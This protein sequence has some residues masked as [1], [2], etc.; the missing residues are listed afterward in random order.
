VEPSHEPPGWWIAGPSFIFGGNNDV[1][2][3][4]KD[5]ARLI[6]SAPDLLKALTAIMSGVANYHFPPTGVSTA[7][8]EVEADALIAARAAIA[9]ATGEENP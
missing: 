7:E 5:D 8:V 6:A 2:L 1:A 4:N 9:R 3:D